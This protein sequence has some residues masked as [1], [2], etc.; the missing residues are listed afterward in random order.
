MDNEMLDEYARTY[1]ETKDP[2]TFEELFRAIQPNVDKIAVIN[3]YKLA[4]LQV[5][6]EDFKSFY[7]EAVW[8]AAETYNGHSHFWQRLF[9]FIRQKDACIYKHYRAKKRAAYLVDC[10]DEDSTPTVE[11]DFT[12]DILDKEI[13]EGFLAKTSERDK[14]IVILYLLNIQR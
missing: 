7:Y 4:L 6:I 13:L 3:S 12:G 2:D 8:E 11:P 1:A 14:Q 9:T 10:L 5:P